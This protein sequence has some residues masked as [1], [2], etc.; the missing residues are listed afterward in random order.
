MPE[1]PF[2]IESATWIQVK[3]GNDT[4]RSI[5]DRHYGR[6]HYA[7]GRKPLLF[8]G[9]GQKMV[10]LTSDAKA[11]FVW[12]KFISM[13]HQGGGIVRRVPQREPTPILRSHSRSRSN[14]VGTL[15]GRA[16]LHLRGS[17]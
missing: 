12:R 7:D 8:V 1:Q 5:F 4:A 15:A 2:L 11:L 17:R 3:D 10:L 16:T 9:P 14:R 13:D 6:Y